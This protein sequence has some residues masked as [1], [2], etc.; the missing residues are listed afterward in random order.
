MLDRASEGRAGRSRQGR[1][2]GAEQDIREQDTDVNLYG[3]LNQDCS[4]VY[5]IHYGHPN[6]SCSYLQA[7]TTSAH[8]PTAVMALF[9]V[10]VY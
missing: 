1:E 3:S 8:V 6:Q 7:I 2:G 4:P 9:I 5:S 10:N